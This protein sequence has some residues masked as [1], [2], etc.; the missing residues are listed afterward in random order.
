[1]RIGKITGTVTATSRNSR[2]ST[3]P[4]LVVDL[5]DAQ[6]NVIE[7]SIVASDTVGAGVGQIVLVA[8][9][10]AARIADELQGTISDAAVVAIV[11]TIS[12]N[13]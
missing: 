12:V 7:K 2:L 6:G 13:T 5:E 4:L 11:D 1:M 3:H 9:G 10:S 8:T